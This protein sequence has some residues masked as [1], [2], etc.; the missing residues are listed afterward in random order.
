MFYAM[1]DENMKKWMAFCLMLCMCITMVACGSEEAAVYV[2]SVE[3][4]SNMGGIAP[5]DMFAGVVVSENITE[6]Q[7]D[8]EMTVEELLVRSGDDVTEG[9]ELFRYDTQKLQLALDKARLE[10]EQMEATIESYKQQI[11]ELEKERKKA[12]ESNKLEYTIQIQSVQ[13][14]LKE[15]EINIKA[16]EAAVAQ[17]EALMENVVVTAPVSGRIQSISESGTDNYGNPVAYITIQQTGSYRV[18]G[19][20]G[21]LQRGAIMEGARLEILSRTDDAMWTGTVTLIDY[22]SPVQDNQNMM[23]YG[24]GS[25]E[26]TTSSKYPFYVELD[27]TEGLLLGQ[28]VYL[29][30]EGQEETAGGISIGSAFICYEETDGSTYVWAENRG[31]LEK[32]YVTLGEYSM[33]NDSYLVLSG[34]TE[35][36]YIAFADYELCREGVPTTRTEPVQDTTVSDMAVESVVLG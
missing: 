7:K 9:Q 17:S 19:T 14:D 15:A 31:K 29:R 10:L 32:R 28:H 30:L 35:E 11:D 13:L 27:N 5:G 21:E 25:D 1:E 24:T 16:K 23:Y 33:M 3:V 20:L 36:D 26:M 2:Q 8:H 18:K 22:E 34:L 6:I 12:K 4:L